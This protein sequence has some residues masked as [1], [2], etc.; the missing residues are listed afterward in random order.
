MITININGLTLCHKGSSGVS[1]NT[2]PDVCKTPPFGVPV[3]YENEAYSADLIKGTTSVSADGGNMI[4]NVGS[5]FA[6]SVFDEAGSMG[7][8][9]SGT[10]MAETEWISHSFDVFFE[11]KPACRLTDKLFMNHRNTVNMAGLNQAKIRG[12]NEDNTTP[13]EDEQ[14]EVTLTIGVFFDGTGNNAINLER[15][16]AACDGKHFDINNQDAQFI[17]TEYAKDN[18]GFSDLESGSHTCY[19]TN[20]H[21]LYIAYRSFIEN[22]K[23]KRQA[24]IY[25]QGIGTDAGKP[26]SLVGMGLGEGDTGVLAKT[27][28]AV[29]QLS[30]VIKDLLPSRCIVKTLQFD[31]FGFSRGAAAARHFANRIYH[32]D[33]QLV[34]AIKQGLANRE[35]HSDSAGKTRFIG[36]FDTVA[37]IGTPFNGVNP[38]SADTGDVDL[39]LHAGIAEKVFHIAAQHECR[40]NFALNSVRP[41]WPELVLPGVHSDIGGGYWPNEQENC[42]LTR[43]QAETVPENQPDEST[44]VYRQTFS[45]LKDMESSP[46]IAPIIRTSTITAKTWNDKR[47]PPDHL[48]TPQKRTFAALTLNPRQVKNNWAAVAYLVMLEA[49]TEA[50]CEFRTEDDNRTLLIPPELRPLCNKAL[51]MG[52]AAR[53]GYATAGFTTDEID[54][55]AKQYI[56]CSANWNSVKIDTNNNIVGGAKPLALIFANRPDERWLRTIYDMDG[57]RKY[58]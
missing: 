52:K 43:P 3:P 20:I 8:I 40:F 12:T 51:A 21:W 37:A 14:T 7:G 46:N 44:H 47:M 54:I 42:F 2:L 38:N 11:K 49:A 45:A 30:G 19:Y 39:T 9:L 1:H 53:S 5:Q 15:M 6:R 57:V 56:H 58:L 26:D 13:K 22:D 27:D 23:R 41:A 36:I 35:Y 25:I 48:G 28:E 50:G 32:K 33:P 24:A 55:L 34:K 17:L 29:T 16:I 31:I 4:A 18:M 10:N